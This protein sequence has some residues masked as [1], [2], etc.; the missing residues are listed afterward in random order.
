MAYPV[1]LQ[2]QTITGTFTDMV[3]DRTNSTYNTVA[4]KGFVSLSPGVD[5]IRFNNVVYDLGDLVNTTYKLDEDGSFSALIIVSNQVGIEPN[6]SWSYD[7]K[8]SWHPDKV[9]KITPTVAGAT[10]D[11]SNIIV[12]DA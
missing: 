10:T 7:L 4:K 8:M 6:N 2:T 9:V 3:F 11:I 5:T 1:G 12:P